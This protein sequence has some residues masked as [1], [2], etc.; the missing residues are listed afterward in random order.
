MERRTEK[1][2]KQMTVKPE[3]QKFKDWQKN[4]LSG[5]EKKRKLRTLFFGIENKVT[6]LRHNADMIISLDDARA[7]HQTAEPRGAEM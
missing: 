1:T 4:L 2:N 3:F 6:F 5:N 7:C